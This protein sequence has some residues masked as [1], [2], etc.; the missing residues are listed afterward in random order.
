MRESNHKLMIWAIAAIL[1][2]VLSSGL[3]ISGCGGGNHAE[4]FGKNVILI[5]IDSLRSDHCGYYGYDKPTTPMM[6]Q[7]AADPKSVVF[8]QS[9]AASPWTSPSH[10]SMLTGLYPQVHGVEKIESALNSNVPTI[11]SVMSENGYRTF[12]VVCAPYLSERFGLNR[13]FENYD[14]SLTYPNPG[15]TRNSK[16]AF[17]VTNRALE[18]VDQAE[19]KPFFLFLHYWDVHHPYNPADKYLEIFDSK[20]YDGPMDGYRIRRRADITPEMAPRDLEHLIALYDGEIR[21]TDKAI[22]KLIEQLKERG[23]YDDTMIIITADHGD[24]FLDHGGKAHMATC[25]NEVVKVPLVIRMPW[26]KPKS[27]KMGQPVNHVDLFPT[28]MG[29]MEIPD[30]PEGLDG[31]SLAASIAKGEPIAPRDVLS[32]TAIG[33]VTLERTGPSGI[34]TSYVTPDLVK[35]HKLVHPV[36]AFEKV[37]DLNGDPVEKVDVFMENPEQS[38][39]LQGRMF[40]YTTLFKKKKEAVKA[41]KTITFDKEYQEKLESLGYMQ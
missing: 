5:S 27:P 6:D 16:L 24:E 11:A 7:F 12:G 19:G 40:T 2:G 10:A 25:Y 20:P 8:E 29:A 4:K 1:V 15:V 33:R 30:A 13:G 37:F 3:L 18:Y 35:F 38:K 34:W 22:G 14:T 41:G 32:R 36:D 17:K 28:I 21:Y 26:A 9:Y 39:A 31:V 23:V